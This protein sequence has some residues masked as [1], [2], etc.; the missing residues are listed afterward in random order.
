MKINK[1][2]L[3]HPLPTI[4]YNAIQEHPYS[5]KEFAMNYVSNHPMARFINVLKANHIYH[6]YGVICMI[7][8]LKRYTDRNWYKILFKHFTHTHKEIED[9]VGSV[10]KDDINFYLK[11]RPCKLCSKDCIR[12]FCSPKCANKYKA[13][14]PIYLAKLSKGVENWYKNATEEELE[15]KK[16]CISEGNKSFYDNESEEYRIERLKSFKEKAQKTYQEKYSVKWATQHPEISKRANETREKT[17]KEKYGGNPMKTKECLE[18]AKKTRI[19][20]GMQIPDEDLSDYELYR[21]KV[22]AL[23]ERN[24]KYV[25]GIEER[26]MKMHIDHKYSIYMGFVNKIPVYLIASVENLETMDSG[27]NI[28]KGIACSIAIEDLFRVK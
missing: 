17:N 5:L 2:L 24:A 25:D 20:K 4:D 23:T 14:D 3:K 11:K 18:K 13:K 12:D 6:L 21:K 19:D 27:E 1:K 8:T 9:I 22:R 28:S 16:R 10:G 26:S 15:E 7:K